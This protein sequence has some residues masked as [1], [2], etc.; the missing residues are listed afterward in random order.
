MSSRTGSHTA[1]GS[2]GIR[3]SLTAGIGLVSG[4]WVAILV[5]APYLV[6][7]PHAPGYGQVAAAAAY[8]A[9]G[10][11]CHQRSDRSFHLWDS[12]M[13]VCARC[14]G[15]YAAVPLGI[16]GVLGYRRRWGRGMP[17][18]G[19]LW[20]VRLLRNVL[21]VASLPTLVTFGLEVAAVAEPTN[22]V[23]AVSALPLGFG[24]AWIVGLSLTGAVDEDA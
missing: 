11:V 21:L 24:V 7:H 22:I 16:V 13:P 15:L 5:A 2:I 23:R 10:V 12:Q 1:A 19:R 8:V 6:A 18:P 4:L 9:G 17:A 3:R 14:S 20:P